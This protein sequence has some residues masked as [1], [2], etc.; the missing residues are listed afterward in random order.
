MVYHTIRRIQQITEKMKM[1]AIVV[2]VD[3]TAAFDHVIRPWL[4][5]S[6]YQRL[7]GGCNHN[8]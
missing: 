5:K 4:F 8:L 2:I 7:S 6:I 3:L 1:L